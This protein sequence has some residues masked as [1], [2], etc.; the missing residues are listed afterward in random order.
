MQVALKTA[1]LNT[2]EW[3]LAVGAALVGTFWMEVGKLL[4]SRSDRESEEQRSQ[5]HRP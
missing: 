2:Q 1:P 4:G 5:S 3:A